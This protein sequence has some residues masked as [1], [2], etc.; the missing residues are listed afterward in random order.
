MTILRVGIIIIFFSLV[1]GFSLVKS[2]LSQFF[3]DSVSEN[4]GGY[5]IGSGAIL[6]IFYVAFELYRHNKRN[7]EKSQA[8]KDALK[9][10]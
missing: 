2:F 10:S 8:V 1:F 9:N 3:N 4:L 6:F 7:K 5:I